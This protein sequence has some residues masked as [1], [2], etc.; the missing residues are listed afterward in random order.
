[1]ETNKPTR[2]TTSSRSPHYLISFKT[3]DQTF[4]KSLKNSKSKKASCRSFATRDSPSNRGSTWGIKS[5]FKSSTWRW[6]RLVRKETTS[7][8]R[9]SWCR[10][11]LTYS[12]EWKSRMR[13]RSRWSR[14]MSVPATRPSMGWYTSV[15]K[16]SSTW[17]NSSL[18]TQ[19]SASLL[20]GH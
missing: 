8:F 1:M 10:T 18:K 6:S 13:T 17:R 11:I 14:K 5:A 12:K 20:I 3:S 9:F 16:S 4:N 15:K 7:S 19:M 2:G